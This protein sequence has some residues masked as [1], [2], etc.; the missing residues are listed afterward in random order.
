[1]QFKDDVRRYK[2]CID[3]FVEEQNEQAKHHQDAADEAI[4]EWNRFVRYELN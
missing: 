2:K 3:A 1:M 4:E